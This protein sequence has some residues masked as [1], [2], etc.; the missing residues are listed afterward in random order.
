MSSLL[1]RNIGQK[2]HVYQDNYYNSV[3]LAQTLLD[4]NVRANRGIPRDLEE[5]RK[6]LKKGHSAF[7]EK[8]M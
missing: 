4:R 6:R 8:V 2:H 5:D 1:D 3:R 7:G